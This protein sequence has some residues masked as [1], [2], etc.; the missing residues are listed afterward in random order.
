M[1]RDFSFTRKVAAMEPAVESLNEDGFDSSKIGS[2]RT[3]PSASKS[4][5]SMLDQVV[6][7]ATNF[8]F[9]VVVARE[10]GPEGF[11]LIAICLAIAFAF[12]GVT[13]A[14]AAE[15]FLILISRGAIPNGPVSLALVLAVFTA[16]L[17]TCGAAYLAG[18][19]LQPLFFLLA[20]LLVPL[21][22]Q[23]T[24]RYIFFA[25][26]KPH[27]ALVSDLLWSLFQMVALIAVVMTGS[28]PITLLASWGMGISAGAIFILRALRPAI[29]WRDIR[30]WLQ[31]SH[32]FGGWTAAQAIVGQIGLHFTVIWT[33]LV[34]S[35][36][37]AGGFR[38]GQIL[39]GP[40]LLAIAGHAA[41]LLPQL[42]HTV[43]VGDAVQFRA[44]IRRTFLL[45]TVLSVAYAALL[46]SLDKV[47]VLV[48][49][50]QYLRFTGLAIPIAI[51]AVAQGIALAP[52]MGS[53]ALSA[54]KSLL[55]TQAVATLVGVPVIIWFASFA[56]AM[57]AAWGFSVQLLT[58][59]IMSWLTFQAAWRRF[60]SDRSG[61]E[62][63]A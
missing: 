48:F 10:L 46:V 7:S 44:I 62:S 28:S 58:L 50:G 34:S 25:L 36:E 43:A 8:A 55:A 53:R 14:V 22:I 26:R 17:L 56:G 40:L 39:L 49:G 23:D 41:T 30:N 60:P 20:F 16:G 31:V 21:S 2:V 45:G 42:G 57:G 6:S 35:V 54:G 19:E 32:S 61:G 59:S 52:G 1:P 3:R 4:A 9:G 51:G 27:K 18:S 24:G 63:S 33:A 38:A 37:A 15:P 12:M 29:S 5:W 47:I 13:R 11:G